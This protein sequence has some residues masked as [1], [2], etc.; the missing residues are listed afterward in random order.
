MALAQDRKA[1]WGH[2]RVSPDANGKGTSRPAHDSSDIINQ[3]VSN[4]NYFI[5]A[6]VSS[7]LHVISEWENKLYRDSTL[8]AKGKITK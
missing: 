4:M 5:D 1:C 2:W 3:T 8:S 7:G 6:E